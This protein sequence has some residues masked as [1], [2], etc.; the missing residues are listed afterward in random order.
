MDSLFFFF[1]HGERHLSISETLGSTTFT[2]ISLGTMFYLFYCLVVGLVEVNMVGLVEVPVIG[3]E[4]EDI[5]GRRRIVKEIIAKPKHAVKPM[6]LMRKRMAI[7][8]NAVKPMTLKLMR[9]AHL[10]DAVKPVI[11]TLMR[12]AQL[13]NAMKPVILRMTRIALPGNA[14]KPVIMKIVILK[15]TRVILPVLEC[16]DQGAGHSRVH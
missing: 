3:M 1:F 6:I 2:I 15:L 13:G 12:M 7:L 9:K 8:R 16:Q 10:R 4:Y 5:A 11:M 14:V